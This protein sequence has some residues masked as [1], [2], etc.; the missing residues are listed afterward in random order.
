M[1][2]LRRNALEGPP[3]RG[4]D[5]P[6]RAGRHAE[7][8][9]DR[10]SLSHLSGGFATAG[11]PGE[12]QSVFHDAAA[13]IDAGYRSDAEL[14]RGRYY[15]IGNLFE[16]VDTINGL[17]WTQ[18]RTVPDSPPAANVVVPFTPTAT[19]GDVN[20]LELA[21]GAPDSADQRSPVRRL[22]GRWLSNRTIRP[23]LGIAGCLFAATLVSYY[24]P[25]GLARSRSI[26]VRSPGMKNLWFVSV[27][28]VFLAIAGWLH[29]RTCWSIRGGRLATLVPPAVVIQ[30]AAAL[31][32]PL[33]S[34]DIFSNLAN[35]RLVLAGLNPLHR[36]AAALG[37]NHP[38]ASLVGKDWSTVPTPYGPVITGLAT[39]A[40]WPR[41]IGPLWP[42]SN[43]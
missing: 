9:A 30:L 15:D 16:V 6:Q 29:V 23:A 32:L 40:A 12:S 14:H 10:Q 5:Q 27:A 31:A 11:P 19:T 42:C 21:P 33:T 8:A 24:V 26:Q 18:R 39:V 20:A 38:T 3:A 13:T 34:N 35:G 22:A 43:C 7:S 25:G 17:P 37:P 4:F 41:R 36:T 1:E 28:V 2:L